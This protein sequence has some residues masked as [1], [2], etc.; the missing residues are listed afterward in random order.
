MEKDGNYL[1]AFNEDGESLQNAQTFL[2]E[3]IFYCEVKIIK[4]VAKDDAFLKK[5][6]HHF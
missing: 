3:V 1:Y 6:Q 5:S 2:V 4:I